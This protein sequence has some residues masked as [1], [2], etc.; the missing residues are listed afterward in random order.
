MAQPIFGNY[1]GYYQK[2]PAIRDPR[3]SLFPQSFFNNKDV[4]DVGCNEGLVSIE[5][6]ELN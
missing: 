5:I 4:L 1:Q 6:G 3:L 2:R